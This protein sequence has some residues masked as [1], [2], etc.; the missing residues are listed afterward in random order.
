VV[1]LGIRAVR[2]GCAPSRVELLGAVCAVGG[3]AVFLGAARPAPGLPEHLPSSLVVAAAVVVC[4]GLVAMAGRLPHGPVGALICGAI[5]EV[6]AGA[7]AVLISTALEVLGQGAAMRVR[8]SSPSLP[9]SQPRSPPWRRSSAP[10][11]RTPAARW[12]GRYPR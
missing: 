7:A 12:R 1:A 2:E 4:L 9:W 8:V 6:V 10:S 3:L 5:A 11:R